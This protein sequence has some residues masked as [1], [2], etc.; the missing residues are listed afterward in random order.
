MTFIK[1]DTIQQYRD[2]VTKVDELRTLLQNKLIKLGAINTDG[3]IDINNENIKCPSFSLLLTKATPEDINSIINYNLPNKPIDTTQQ[4]DT[5]NDI[6]DYLYTNR[7]KTQTKIEAQTLSITQIHTLLLQKFMFYHKY[8]QYEL[9][10][11]GIS[12]YDIDNAKTLKNLILLL[13][14]ID[15]MKETKII[16]NDTNNEIYINEDNIV[17]IKVFDKYDDILVQTG[18]INIYENNIKL[19]TTPYDV[20]DDIIITPTSLGNHT[21]II[22]YIPSNSE[23]N[24]YLPCTETITLKVV[25][26]SLDGVVI[27][28]NITET[29][30]FYDINSIDDYEGYKEDDWDIDITIYNSRGNSINQSIPFDVYLEDDVFLFN[31]VTNSL[32]KAT[33]H[34]VNIPYYTS[35]FVHPTI[36]HFTKMDYPIYFTDDE[37]LRNLVFIK[38]LQINNK[39]ISYEIV[40]LYDDDYLDDINGC[41]K[42]LRIDDQSSNV[43]YELY[44]SNEHTQIKDVENIQEELYNLVTEILFDGTNIA[45]E[46]VGSQQYS[47]L[48]DDISNA[49]VLKVKTK[50]NNPTY[51]DINIPHKINLYHNPLSVDQ[52]DL[53]WYKTDPNAPTGVNI[54]INNEDTGKPIRRLITPYNLSINNINITLTEPTYFFEYS[55]LTLNYGTNDLDLILKTQNDE[56]ISSIHNTI[57]ILSNFITPSETEF[58]LNNTPEIYY[59]PLGKAAQNKKV[60][61]NYPT[62]TKQYSTKKNGLIS[63]IQTWLNPQRYNLTITANSDNLTE[64]INYSYLLKIPFTITQTVYNQTSQTKYQI[65][66]LNTQY[67][68]AYTII[69]NETGNIILTGTVQAGT[70]VIKT[71]TI[72]KDNNNLGNNTLTVNSNGYEEQR[73]FIFYDHI[74]ELQTTEINTGTNKIIKIKCLDPNITTMNISGTGITQKSITKSGNI[75]TITCDTTQAFPNGLTLS[76]SSGNIAETSTLTIL[77]NDIQANITI[78]QS[79]FINNNTTHN[80]ILLTTNLPSSD[81]ITLIFN[82]GI[83]YNTIQYTNNNSSYELIDFYQLDRTP[84]TYEASITFNGNN[85]YNSFSKTITYTILPDNIYIADMNINDGNL[86]ITEIQRKNINNTGIASNLNLG[87]A[88]LLMLFDI[89][90]TNIDTIDNA[91]ESITINNSGNLIISFY[92]DE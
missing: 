38:N 3:S 13:D 55:N 88:D 35:D 2:L 39:E 74:F 19:N 53:T 79:T 83:N 80:K 67:P 84:G 73:T 43:Y 66:N 21:Y 16:Y 46:V 65:T 60:Y 42:N 64:E 85:N 87:N 18:T 70:Q 89:I 91:I 77:K 27:L 7:S 90:G 44:S 52:H 34:N 23:T 86:V 59:K 57:T 37:I 25:Y 58:F 30:R 31:G 24:R 62:G 51:P 48:D 63:T 32:G 41:I 20:N 56:R 26:P 45:Y 82:D 28:H 40:E 81:T 50:L 14:R 71:I 68:C 72:N 17:P 22:E 1:E 78:N 12:K 29:S 33:L 6:V 15:R 54:T 69:N 8:L 4:F 61:I 76:M 11:M 75:F 9:E 47:V 92:D 10:N 5:E 49:L 36:K